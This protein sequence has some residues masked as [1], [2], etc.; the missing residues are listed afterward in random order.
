MRHDRLIVV[1]VALALA[2]AGCAVLTIDV[3]VY[4]GALANHESVQTEQLAAMAMGAKPLIAELRALLERKECFAYLQLLEDRKGT[5][6][7]LAPSDTY[8]N[9]DLHCPAY[10]RVRTT[11]RY[12]PDLD[13]VR[14]RDAIRVNG[15]LSLYEDQEDAKGSQSVRTLED[16]LR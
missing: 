3:D 2:T 15:I 16:R 7:R 8:P 4:K 13:S 6:S 12:L 5:L 9:I 11:A 1:V 14:S 10:F